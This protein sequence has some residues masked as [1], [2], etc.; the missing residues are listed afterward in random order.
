MDLQEIILEAWTGL[1]CLKTGT[2]ERGNEPPFSIKFGEF[3]D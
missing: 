2:G 3:L 1:L